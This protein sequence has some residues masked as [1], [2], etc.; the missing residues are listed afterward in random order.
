MCDQQSLRSACACARSGR[1]LCWSL[2]RFYG[3]WAA[4][5]APFRVSELKWRLCT[6]VWVCACQGAVLLESSCAGSYY[7]FSNQNFSAAGSGM[8]TKPQVV[9]SNYCLFIAYCNDKDIEHLS[10]ELFQQ[11]NVSYIITL[12]VP[13]KLLLKLLSAKVICWTC[14]MALLCDVDIDYR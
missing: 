10:M 3:C 8:Q 2:G 13:E 7:T 14:L 4:D 9:L 5:W 6:L 12:R 1:S 11:N